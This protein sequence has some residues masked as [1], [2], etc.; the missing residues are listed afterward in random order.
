MIST[1]LIASVLTLYTIF[2]GTAGISEGDNNPQERKAENGVV[3][4][5]LETKEGLEAYVKDYFKDEPV[6]YEIAKCESTMRH[7]LPSGSVIRGKVNSSDVGLMQINEIYHL[8]K[9]KSLGF[10]IHTLEGNMAYAKYLFEKEGVQPW[11]SSSKC[12]K[13]TEAYKQHTDA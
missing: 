13:K 1:Q 5:N 8:K 10:D 9:A 4:Y 2:G 6:L 12:W 7:T 3:V 11:S